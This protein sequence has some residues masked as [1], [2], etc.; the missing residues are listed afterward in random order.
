M[1]ESLTLQVSRVIRTSRERA[2][3][4]W[5]SPEALMRWFAP[6]AM[7]VLAAEVDL[8]EGG[9]FRAAVQGPSPRNGQ[10]ISIAFT[11]IYQKIVP[12]ELLS[13]RWE[14]AGDPGEPTMVTVEFR[15]AAGG[16]EV[17]LTQERIPNADIFNRNRS[18]WGGMLDKL[19][20]LEKMAG[21][22]LHATRT[23]GDLAAVAAASLL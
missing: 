6:G 10:E 11:G 20:G 12:G 21:L 14:V 9:V 7:R 2:F 18:G 22:D 3:A 23:R 19:A 13:M 4:A 5:T 15:D 16:T 1:S 17:S 8:R